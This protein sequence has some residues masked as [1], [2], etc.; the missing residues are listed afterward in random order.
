MSR[1]PFGSIDLLDFI[2]NSTMYHWRSNASGEQ[3]D[4][5]RISQRLS[6]ILRYELN[7]RDFTRD[8]NGFVSLQELCV[9]Y[10]R[11]QDEQDVRRIAA[12][13]VG[14]RGN[15]F[16]IREDEVRGPCIRVLH[17]KGHRVE[18]N[19]NRSH[20]W[21]QDRWQQWPQHS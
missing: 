21:E 10:F 20:P 17:N 12:N 6:W 16:E 11:H 2:G 18:R 3:D 7:Q 19:R 4:D 1:S 9:R 14:P 15:R 8:A 5:V 13:S